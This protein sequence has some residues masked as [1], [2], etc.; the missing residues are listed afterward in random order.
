MYWLIYECYRQFLEVSFIHFSPLTTQLITVGLP[1]QSSRTTSAQLK[2]FS[3]YSS[4]SLWLK[5]TSPFQSSFI[6]PDIF[7]ALD[8][9]DYLVYVEALFLS[10]IVYIPAFL[11]GLMFLSLF[12]ILTFLCPTIQCWDFSELQST[13]PSLPSLCYHHS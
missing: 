8:I 9:T 10:F 3:W 1:P 4:R 5:Q 12:Y 6:L 7:E 13:C 11:S 2:L